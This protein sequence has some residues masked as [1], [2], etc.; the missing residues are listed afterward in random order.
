MNTTSKSVEI[1]I[2]IPIADYNVLDGCLVSTVMG[3]I[4]EA[5]Q[6][7]SSR[8]AAKR[9]GTLIGLVGESKPYDS[10]NETYRT[11]FRLGG[12]S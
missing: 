1:T 12:Q 9:P 4:R 11:A 7:C 5:L 10:D 8:F 6:G 2:T 3:E